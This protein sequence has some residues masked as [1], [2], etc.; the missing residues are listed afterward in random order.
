M[1]EEKYQIVAQFAETGIEAIKRTGLRVEAL[2]ERYAKV[3]MP[4]EGNVSHLGTMY[5][6][7][8]FVLGEF[9]GGIIFGVTFDYTK[10][11][12]VVKDISIRFVR[13]AKS[14]VVMEIAM[15]KEKAADIEREA[16][17][18]GKADFSLNLEL[19]DTAGETVTMIDG[20]WQ[21]RRLKGTPNIKI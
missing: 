3:M 14:D 12:P 2:K 6:G 17:K 16:E 7:S 19:K 13:A 8:L 11:V 10:Y 1:I 15:S 20:I 9:S 21:V 5:A 18:Q 4:L